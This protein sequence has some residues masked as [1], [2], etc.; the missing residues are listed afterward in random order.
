MGTN[1]K[2]GKEALN[3]FKSHW[4]AFWDLKENEAKRLVEIDFLQ[5]QIEEIDGVKPCEEDG[6]LDFRLKLARNEEFIRNT[7]QDLVDLI[8]S[9]LVP[10]LDQAQKKITQLLEFD[11]KLKPYQEQIQSLG[12]TLDELRGELNV[13]E[14]LTGDRTLAQLEARESELNRLFMKYGS[15]ITENFRRGHQPAQQIG[16]PQPAIGFPEQPLEHL[17][18]AVPQPGETQAK[19]SPV[20]GPCGRP[21]CHRSYFR[22]GRSGP[23]RGQV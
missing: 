22:I 23:G 3:E 8:G 21:I 10:D 1:W 19:T 13:W 4:K 16:V 5:H 20:T 14:D 6:D 7:K 9:Q 18:E 2:T 11:G 15:T 17:G 12:I